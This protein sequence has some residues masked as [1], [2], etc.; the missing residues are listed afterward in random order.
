MLLSQLTRVI[1]GLVPAEHT[2]A[3]IS[4]YQRRAEPAHPAADGAPLRVCCRR[5][6][7]RGC[8]EHQSSSRPDTE[9]A[10]KAVPLPAAGDPGLRS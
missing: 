4:D 8:S 7:G 6:T 10:A 1:L 2:W 9:C 3:P 5:G